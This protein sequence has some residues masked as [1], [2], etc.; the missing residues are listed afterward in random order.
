MPDFSSLDSETRCYAL[1]GQYLYR[2]TELETCLNAAIQS[3]MRIHDLMRFILCANINL[4][5]KIMIL[6]VIVDVSNLSDV[7]RKH[8]DSVLEKILNNALPKRNM[9]AH[10]SFRPDKN[11]VGVEFLQVSAKSIFK[12]PSPV[13]SIDDFQ[14]EGA[15][16]DEF[17]VEMARLMGKLSTAEFDHSRATRLITVIEPI[18]DAAAAILRLSD[19]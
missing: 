13:W 18:S 15:V 1:V 12:L 10:V 2:L 7:E 11:G 19:H 6:R 8:F 16:I 9:F 4:R 17:S 5:Q 3:A 14:R